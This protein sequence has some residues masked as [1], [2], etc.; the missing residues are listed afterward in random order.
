MV[1]IIRKAALPLPGEVPSSLREAAAAAASI[2]LREPRPVGF[3]LLFSG[4]MQIIEAAVAYLHEHS[5]QRAHTADTLRTYAEI[6]HDW[7]DTLEQNGIIW[8]DA[9]G[10]DLVAYRN[11]MLSQSSAHT[12]RPYSVRTINH[13]VRGV[14]RFYEWAVRTAWLR[15]SSLAGRDNEFALS[16]GDGR[17]PHFG[18]SEPSQSFF[19]LRQFEAMPRPL[20]STQARE[21]LARLPSPYDLMARWQI[22]TGLR[23]SELLRLT[24]HDIVQH[25]Q[26]RST[27]PAV[28]HHVIGLMRKAGK[29]GYVI[30]SERLLEETDNYRRLQ[31]T[32]WTKRWSETDGPR[33]AALFIGLRGTAVRK[34]TYQQVI[35]LAGQDCGFF[36]TTHLLRATF[37]C[38]ML[39][40]LEQ[41]AKAGE[42]VNPL[43][44]VKILMGHERISTTDRYLRAIAVDAHVLSESIDS[45]LGDLP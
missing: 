26:A 8:S 43:L 24:V 25:D 27:G 30:A 23:V 13:R 19:V 21:L 42:A 1:Q 17:T 20:T 2:T 3:P 10:A 18:R 34:N 4:D 12:G 38:M 15:Q 6:L 40:R 16:R 9:D 37:A 35:R 36:A 5:V 32:A 33:E 22:Y 7:F 41:V 45:L 44:V 14:L 29:R 31:R 28:S 39:A 11:R